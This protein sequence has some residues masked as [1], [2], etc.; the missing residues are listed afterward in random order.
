MIIITLCSNPWFRMSHPKVTE[1]THSPRHGQETWVLPPTKISRWPFPSHT[2][3]CVLGPLGRKSTSP[4]S[5]ECHTASRSCITSATL[6]CHLWAQLSCPE[7]KGLDL[8]RRPFPA[9]T[10][11]FSRKAYQ[12]AETPYILPCTRPSPEIW[13]DGWNPVYDSRTLP[14]LLPSLLAEKL[15]LN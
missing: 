7:I 5:A 4:P 6:L 14:L 8:L 9:L 13:R 1:P 11:S 2:H 15:F 10:F 12:C 3:Q